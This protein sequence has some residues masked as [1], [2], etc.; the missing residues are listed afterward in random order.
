MAQE[1]SFDVVARTNL[2]EVDNAISQ[3]VK[4]IST[5]Y[6]FKGSPARVSREGSAVSLLAESDYRLRSVLDILQN[7]LAK[8]GVPLKSLS[9]GNPEPA[10]GAAMRQTA[11]IQ[12]GIP[13]EKA[14]EMVKAIKSSGLKVQVSIQ[15]DQLRISGKSKDDLQTAMAHLR[16]QD[17]G[18]ALEF[19]NYR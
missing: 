12:E 8:R 2:Q 19:V 18:L 13:Q 5:R 1:F 3:A 11:Q 14:K 7:K 6:D 15:G 9:F 4:E 16:A 17:F 10:A